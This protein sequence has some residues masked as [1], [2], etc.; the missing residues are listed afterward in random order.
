VIFVSFSITHV[1]E[2]KISW[3]DCVC[4][5]IH[6]KCHLK[7]TPHWF[8]MTYDT[9]CN[10]ECRQHTQCRPSNYVLTMGQI[11]IVFIYNSRMT[12]T[13][14]MVIKFITSMLIMIYWRFHF[15]NEIPVNCLFAQWK[16][17]YILDWWPWR[18][19]AL[20]MGFVDKWHSLMQGHWFF[21]SWVGMQQ[22][23]VGSRKKR[24]RRARGGSGPWANVI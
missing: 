14:L 1:D 15:E 18:W 4:K 23:S 3:D 13:L 24:M 17:T 5:L 19:S 7:N 20:N 10:I 22:F 16:W 21:R 6:K 9:K 8:K 11:L 2:L 12:K